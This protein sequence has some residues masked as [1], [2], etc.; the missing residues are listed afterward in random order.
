MFFLNKK[1]KMN[2]GM[3]YVELIVVLAIFAVMNSIIIFNYGIF[4]AKVD[5][6]NLGSDIA[7]KIVEAQKASFSGRLP[8][9]TPIP[10]WKPAYGIYFNLNGSNPTALDTTDNIAF[11]KKFIYFRDLN[12]DNF[13][14]DLSCSLPAT[15][16]SG[17]C[18]DK[19]SIT[20]NNVI[21]SIVNCTNLNCTSSSPITTPF[22]IT[23]KRSSSGVV[24]P[25]VSNSGVG[26]CV[27]NS[28]NLS[29]LPVPYYVQITVS[30]PDSNSK[31]YIKVY[32]SG[33]IQVN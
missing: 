23:F 15:S 7:S 5:I 25:C 12:D 26:F 14:D 18:L 24:G 29:P 13:D 31:A 8:T 28:G 20:K 22:A 10:D 33:R 1:V 21:S 9:Q 6:K 19:I 2:K 32:S 4:Q 27:S 11:N 16:T 3:S 30:S 17:E